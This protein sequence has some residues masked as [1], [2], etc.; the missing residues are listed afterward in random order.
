[1]KI[2]EWQKNES[3]NE[4]SISKWKQ[5]AYDVMKI[6]CEKCDGSYIQKKSTALVWHYE[7]A[8]PHYG[9][10][11]ATEAERYLRRIIE[12]HHNLVVQRY[13][14]CRALEVL[15]KEIHKGSAS[16]K[17]IDEMMK[18]IDYNQDDNTGNNI[19]IMAVGNDR[20]DEKMFEAVELVSKEINTEY[21]F[22][23]RIGMAPTQARFYLTD[24]NQMLWLLNTMT[25]IQTQQQQQQ[26]NNNSYFQPLVAKEE[27]TQ[28]Q[29]PMATTSSNQMPPRIK[30]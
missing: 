9:D 6:Y 10:M 2:G 20:S 22:T 18:K 24:Q 7:N 25:S 23:V 19:F 29:I 13:D 17:V 16:L 21:G 3:L 1:M 26:Q 15:P 30:S 8:D 12:K 5:I 4:V 11:Q 14:H 28:V 27:A